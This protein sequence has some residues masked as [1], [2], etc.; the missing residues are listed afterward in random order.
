MLKRHTEYGGGLSASHPLAEMFW[1]VL[2]GMTPEEQ[3]LVLRFTF[4]RTRLPVTDAG[5]TRCF[6]LQGLPASLSGNSD[7]RLPTGHTC[8]FQLCLPRYSSADVLRTQL[9]RAASMCVG[10]DLDDAGHGG[11]DVVFD[12]DTGSGPE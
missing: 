3:G 9:L 1:A 11:G 6:K 5:Y 10:Y 7:H 4:G 2:A 12:D 8:V